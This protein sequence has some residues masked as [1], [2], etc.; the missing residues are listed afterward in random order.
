MGN[1]RLTIYILKTYLQSIY[2]VKTL[3]R[4]FEN[5]ATDSVSDRINTS[6]A[7]IIYHIAR[8]LRLQKGNMTK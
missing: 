8:Q 2:K 4:H 7:G 5:F 6:M 1:F 3:N